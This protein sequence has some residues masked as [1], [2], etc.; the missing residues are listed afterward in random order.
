FQLN[1]LFHSIESLQ[2][3][4][5][6]GNRTT[7]SDYFKFKLDNK[8][9]KNENIDEI[10][11]IEHT[12]GYIN[13]LFEDNK[14][15]RISNFIIKE[16]HSIIT[17]GL[18]TEG[19]VTPGCYRKTEVAIRNSKHKPPMAIKVQ[20]YMDELINWINSDAK[21]YEKPLKA[22]IAHHRFTWIHPFDNGNGRMSRLLTYFLLRQYGYRMSY[23]M[24]L[25]A[26]FCINREMYFDM[27]EKADSGNNKELL[28][29]CEYVLKGLNTEIGKMQKLLDKKYWL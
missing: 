20:E 5:I 11:N 4:R 12:I 13:K 15:I 29:W 14:D 22:A 18:V 9:H 28:E 10:I 25:S 24:N 27:L 26:I 7:L 2:S 19:S 21:I 23:L 16:L 1:K 6:E 8:K 3:A 17:N